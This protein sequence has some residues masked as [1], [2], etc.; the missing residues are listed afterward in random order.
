M[1]NLLRVNDFHST[2]KMGKTRKKMSYFPFFC[3]NW[4]IITIFESIN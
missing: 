1:Y 4:K 2:G 3:T